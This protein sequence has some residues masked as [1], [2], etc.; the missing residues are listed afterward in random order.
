MI[1]LFCVAFTPASL[2]AVAKAPLAYMAAEFAT[3]LGVLAAIAAE[4]ATSK[5]D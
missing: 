4:L 5:D 3:W 1:E 2:L